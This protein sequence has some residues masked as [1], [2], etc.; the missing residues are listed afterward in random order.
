[1]K[2]KNC[3]RDIGK[4]KFC[5]YCGKK[6]EKNHNKVVKVVVALVCCISIITVGL[7]GV[8]RFSNKDTVSNTNSDYVFF[9]EG[10][11]DVILDD[12]T[13][14]ETSAVFKSGD[15][16]VYVGDKIIYAKNDGIYYRDNPTSS[17]NKIASTQKDHASPQNA[18]N[19]LSDGETVFF[20][21]NLGASA[22]NFGAY[23][24]QDEVYSVKVNG[25]NLSKLFKTEGDVK[26]I[27]CYI[28]TI[29]IVITVTPVIKV[30]IS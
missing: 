8:L 20:T 10:F 1:M 19:L 12:T 11:T 2:C 7:L 27:T 23:Y 18:R 24:Q 13:T 29:T 17:E 28:L 25:E 16:L 22:D 26:L 15:S 6:N 3:G 30:I 5:V 21:V 9:T 4:E 14:D